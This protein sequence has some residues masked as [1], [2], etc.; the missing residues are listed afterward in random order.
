MN[1]KHTMLSHCCTA[2]ESS[3]MNDSKRAPMQGKN[4]QMTLIFLYL[5]VR[6]ISQLHKDNISRRQMHGN[7]RTYP[8]HND[9]K[10]IETQFGSRWAPVRKHKISVRYRKRLSPDAKSTRYQLHSSVIATP[11]YGLLPPGIAGK[12]LQFA[13]LRAYLQRKRSSTAPSGTT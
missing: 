11:Y 6:C 5:P 2:G 1:V 13:A 4:P 3:F 9:P 12:K 7:V 8:A 10:E